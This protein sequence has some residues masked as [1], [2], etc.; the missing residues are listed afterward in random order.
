MTP[1]SNNQPAKESKPWYK[2]S[3]DLSNL[4]LAKIFHSGLK[5]KKSK[6]ISGSSKKLIKDIRSKPAND[7]ADGVGVENPDVLDI[8]LIKDEVPVIFD[9][10]KNL[11]TLGAFIIL[12]LFLVFEI[13]FFLYSWE[14]QEIRK[15]AV[16]LQEEAAR[17]DQEISSFKAQAALA[18]EF[19]NEINNAS[20]VFNSHIYWTNLLSFLERNT[21]ADVYYSGLTGDTSGTYLLH[22][23]AKDF[24]AVSFQLTTILKDTDHTAKA[25]TSNAKIV[26]G[27][28]ALGTTFDLGLSIK[29]GI[30]TE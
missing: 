19:K 17:L 28:P 5:K 18:T 24:R 4:N 27:D 1:T 9:K 6:T 7:G 2:K 30:F 25:E 16:A 3:L 23:W 29:P 15:K 26:S 20:Q 21:L 11:Y 14:R 13:Y 22:S 12:S 8:D 10:K